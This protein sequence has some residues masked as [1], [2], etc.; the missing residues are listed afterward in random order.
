MV[1]ATSEGR[2]PSLELGLQFELAHKLALAKIK[3]GPECRLSGTQAAAVMQT[4]LIT[5]KESHTVEEA[6]ALM[7]ERT[8]KIGN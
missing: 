7:K 1:K 6:I 8:R 4:Y 2:E 5:I 3:R